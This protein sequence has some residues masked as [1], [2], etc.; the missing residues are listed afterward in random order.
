MLRKQL[1]AAIGKEVQPT[2]FTNY[3]RFHN[4]KLYRSLSSYLLISIELVIDC[5]LGPEYQ[6]RPFCYAVRRPAH[7]PEGTLSI[8]MQ[9]D[10]GLL[11][12][13]IY[14]SV[15]YAPAVKPMKFALSAASEVTFGGDRYVRSL[16]HDG[17]WF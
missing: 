9:L 17:V 2:D 15:C 11:A 6:P 16:L 4:R 5:R 7:V 3:L 13:P 1:I 10:D 8:E 14:T 12:D